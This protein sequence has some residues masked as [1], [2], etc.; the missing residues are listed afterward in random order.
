MTVL[1]NQTILQQSDRKYHVYIPDNPVADELP[2]IL[3]F[4]G[5]GQSVV[6]IA[7]RWGVD[8]NPAH[9]NPPP[10]T[11]VEN[12]ILVFPEADAHLGNKWV[13]KTSASGGFP[14]HDLRFI[15]DLITELTTTAFSTLSERTVNV[16]P[17]KIY[18]AGFSNGAGMVWQLAYSNLVQLFQGFATVGQALIPEKVQSFSGVPP[19]IPIIYTHGTADPNFR[20]PMLQ[21]EA[22]IGTT[23]PAY[24]V[25]EMFRRNGIPS[26]ATA[27]NTQLIPGSTNS[28]EVIAQLFLGNAAF[29]AVTIINGG[30]NWPTPMTQGNPPVASHFNATEMI[31]EFWRNHAGLP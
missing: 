29:S 20:S 28:T 22:A 1:T 18:A 13:H 26:G 31:L 23:F 11:Q 4:H 8:L 16:N 27:T 7:S 30:H 5:V 15:D 2:A 24:T 17:E 3:V 12:Y 19:A 9:P 6:T 25:Q 10:P 14:D 21:R